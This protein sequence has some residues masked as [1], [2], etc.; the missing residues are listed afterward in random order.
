VGTVL[1][2]IQS[3]NGWFGEGDEL[4]FIDGDPTPRIQGTGVEDYFNEAWGLRVSLGPYT[5]VT[6]A[7]GRG[8][9]AR[10]SAYRWHLPD[11]I[12]FRRSLR[13]EMEHAGWTYHSDGTVRSAFEERAD[14]FSSVAFWYQVG[15]SSPL[16]EPPYGEA[17]L[18]HGNARQIEVEDAVAETKSEGGTVRVDKEVFWSRDLLVFHSDGPGSEV[19]IPFNVDKAGRYELISQIAH[20]PDYGIYT[21][22]LD[23]KPIDG[24]APVENKPG[25]R[26]PTGAAA[27]IDAYYF[28]TYVAEDHLLGWTELTAGRHVLT[29]KCLSKNQES[30]GYDLGIDTLILARI[31]RRAETGGEK[32]ANLRQIG[33]KGGSVEILASGLKDADPWV[34][35]AAAWAFTQLLVASRLSIPKLETAMGDSDPVVRGLAA[36]AIGTCPG[37]AKTALA[38]LVAGLQDADE[39]VRT[40]AADAL[41]SAGPDAA[42]VVPQLIQAASRSGEQMNV[43]RNVAKALGNIGPA[44][45]PALPVLEQLE[46]MQRVQWSAREAVRKIRN[47]QS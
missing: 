25:T 46:Q 21:Y 47:G 9:G 14:L 11:P 39:N 36:L 45:A 6:I 24:S 23:G 41:A 15:D 5:G 27:Q 1:N 44:A 34:R 4:F 33:V 22:L 16:P 8:I 43:L 31:G 30:H 26:L 40:A 37:A 17:R 38:T 2:V 28:E 10:L 12:P 35:E 20:R 29:F 3:E 13:F 18:P 32:A 19:H 7:G 42:P